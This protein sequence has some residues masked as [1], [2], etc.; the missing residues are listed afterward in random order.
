[1]KTSQL[2]RRLLYMSLA[3]SLVALGGC[4]STVALDRAMIAYDTTMT[5][6]MSKQL[7]LNIAR[8]R[9]NEPMHFTTISNIAA[10]YRFSVNAGMGGALT[11][12]R[13]RA[14]HDR[15]FRVGTRGHGDA[16]PGAVGGVGDLPRG[17]VEVHQ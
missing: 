5:D 14:L 15:G 2:C 7:L 10:T 16:G 3:A 12:D 9:H 17:P 4:A 1:M 13:G 11:G 6:S 8:A